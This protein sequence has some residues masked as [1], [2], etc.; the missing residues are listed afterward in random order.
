MTFASG[1]VLAVALSLDSLGVGVAYGLRRIRAPWSLYLIVTLC[2]GGLMALSMGLGRQLSAYLDPGLA[3]RAGGCILIAV[4]LWQLYQGRQGFR[5]GPAGPGRAPVP[6]PVLRLGLP[7]LGL[8][9]QILVEPAAADV[10]L[11]G[12]ID[13]PESMVLGL[14]L[15]LDSL[16]AG[17]GLAMSGVSLALVPL[18]A[19][20][21]AASVRIGLAAAGL[22]IMDSLVRRAFALPGVLLVFLGV[23]RL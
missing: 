9:A 19:L 13:V 7:P 18:V 6:R 17:L 5:R 8:V 20:S 15:G 14:A 2:A 21:C 11:S 1:V 22:P 23:L 16:A 12:H 3:R 4:G 10:D